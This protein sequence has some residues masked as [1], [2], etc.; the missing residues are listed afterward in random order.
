MLKSPFSK[1]NKSTI[2]FMV[3]D[4]EFSKNFN[5]F[6]NRNIPVA[7]KYPEVLAMYN[8]FE[9]ILNHGKKLEKKSKT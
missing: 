9:N 6:S 8:F 4:C 5:Y 1:L 3:K 2:H 7:S